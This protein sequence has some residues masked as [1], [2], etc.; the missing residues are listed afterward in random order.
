MRKLIAIVCL[1]TFFALQYGKLVSYWHCKVNAAIAQ[2]ICD[3]EKLLID[4]HK[5][6]G[7]NNS[8]VA[9]AKEK[10]EERYLSDELNFNYPP[11]FVHS[12]NHST[13]YITV[14]PE[15]FPASVFQP[16]RA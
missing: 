16:P 10:S 15:G 11:C 3:C 9:I 7:G 5:D 2:A 13:E 6:D 1:T 12:V 14:I 8:P 4:V